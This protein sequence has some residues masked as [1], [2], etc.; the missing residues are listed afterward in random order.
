MP[1][2]KPASPLPDEV[3]RMIGIMI[4]SPGFLSRGDLRG[5]AEM[6]SLAGQKAAYERASKALREA[7][8]TWESTWSDHNQGKAEG[9]HRAAIIIDQLKEQL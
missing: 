5:L 3:E 7:A 2:T 4:D 9:L 8:K 6:A 1:T